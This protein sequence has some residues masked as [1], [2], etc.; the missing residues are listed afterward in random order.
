MTIQQEAYAP[1]QAFLGRSEMDSGWSGQT[2]G[3]FNKLDEA[4]L[5]RELLMQLPAY[6]KHHF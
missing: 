3:L 2:M 4:L 6:V 5:H 1:H